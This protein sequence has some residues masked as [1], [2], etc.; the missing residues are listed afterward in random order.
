MRPFQ[1]DL[2]FVCF[3]L[4]SQGRTRAPLEL[5]KKVGGVVRA[6]EVAGRNVGRLRKLELM[7]AS[8]GARPRG[9]GI[10][11][12]PLKIQQNGTVYFPLEGR[13]TGAEGDFLPSLV[14]IQLKLPDANEFFLLPV[15]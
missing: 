9:T 7:D 13:D 3:F 8:P 10:A 14:N 1:L 4:F 15:C 5:Q 12:L 6:R 2:L 11:S